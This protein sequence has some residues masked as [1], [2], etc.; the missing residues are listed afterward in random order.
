M[1][2]R[3]KKT[4]QNTPEIQEATRKM[5]NSCRSQYWQKRDKRGT[6]GE[7]VEESAGKEDAHNGSSS[8]ENKEVALTKKPRVNRREKKEKRIPPS[9]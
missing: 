3:E 6:E 4:L 7:Y 1:A 9:A 8:A 5:G 2:V